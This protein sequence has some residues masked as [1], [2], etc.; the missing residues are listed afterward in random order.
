MS[1]L[2]PGGGHDLSQGAVDV[3]NGRPHFGTEARGWRPLKCVP[4]L[5]GCEVHDGIQLLPLSVHI[6]ESKARGPRGKGLGSVRRDT[7]FNQV[8]SKLV[9]EMLPVSRQHWLLQP[10]EKSVA[11]TGRVDTCVFEQGSHS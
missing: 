11:S 9:V 5:N 10:P 2:F 1:P 3:C 4:I 7:L 8:L 6:R